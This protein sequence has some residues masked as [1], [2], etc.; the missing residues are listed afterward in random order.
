MVD[1]DWEYAPPHT[2]VAM[3]KDSIEFDLPEDL[4][5]DIITGI[6]EDKAYEIIDEGLVGQ[7]TW[8]DGQDIERKNIQGIFEEYIKDYRDRFHRYEMAVC[9]IN[10]SWEAQHFV[11][12]Q[13]EDEA[14]ILFK[15]KL[16]SAPAYC[17]VFVYSTS[18]IQKPE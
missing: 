8:L 14:I 6:F 11:D 3:V 10:G 5:D 12:A 17:N 1:D 13:S 4:L 7:I 15:K 16:G 18:D 2:L 9:W